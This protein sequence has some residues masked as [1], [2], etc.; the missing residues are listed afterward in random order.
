MT[1]SLFSV[2]V[3]GACRGF[4]DRKLFAIHPTGY[5]FKGTL[6]RKSPCGIDAG[7]SL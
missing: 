5:H 3:D 7:L 6:T 2:D 4:L 1:D